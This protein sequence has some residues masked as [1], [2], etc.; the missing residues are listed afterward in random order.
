[1][2]DK[3]PK[4]TGI[5][6]EE[7][8]MGKLGTKEMR[9]AKWPIIRRQPQ[10]W[11]PRYTRYLLRRPCTQWDAQF[12]TFFLPCLPRVPSAG[13]KPSGSPHAQITEYRPAI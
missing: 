7:W 5:S 10:L 11:E 12:L 2:S 1:M 6:G 9:C 4:S 13:R 3:K 8:S